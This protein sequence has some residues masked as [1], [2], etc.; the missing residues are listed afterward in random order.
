MSN[1]WR[2]HKIPHSRQQSES[3]ESFDL[4]EYSQEEEDYQRRNKLRT[5]FRAAASEAREKQS[6]SSYYEE[7]L[8]KG[9]SEVQASYAA[10]GTR[11][12][13]SAPGQDE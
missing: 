9:L 11:Y 12:A 10:Y 4:E 8:R 6:Q 5:T 1:S 3:F 13:Y 2:Y 7:L